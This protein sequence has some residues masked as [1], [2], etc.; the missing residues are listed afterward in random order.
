MYK[1]QAVNSE[2]TSIDLDMYQLS[3]IKDRE[4]KRIIRMMKQSSTDCQI[5]Y[6]RNVRPNDINYSAICDYD[7]CAYKCVDPKPDFIDYTS[8]DVLYSNDVVESAKSEIIDIFRI[9]FT[10]SYFEIYNELNYRR[11][12]IDLAVS[13]LVENKTPIYDLSLIHI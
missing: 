10:I 8:Y 4:I 6:A 1:R 11:K 5:N 13:E 2:G 7:V 3:E 12:M 9:V